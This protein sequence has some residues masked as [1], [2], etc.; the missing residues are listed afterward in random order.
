MSTLLSIKTAT[1][2][3]SLSTDKSWVKNEIFGDDGVD[4]AMDD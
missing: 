2:L 3:A 4:F 1:S